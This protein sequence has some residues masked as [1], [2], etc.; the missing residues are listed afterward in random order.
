MRCDAIFSIYEVAVKLV[1]L[2]IL[3]CPKDFW[4]FEVRPYCGRIGMTL[5]FLILSSS[6]RVAYSL[7]SF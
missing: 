4:E 5:V 2:L 6:P 3:N 1:L 7:D